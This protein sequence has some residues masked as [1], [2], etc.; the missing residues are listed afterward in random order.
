[1]ARSDDESTQAT[2]QLGERADSL[3]QRAASLN[4]RSR[5]LLDKVRN[6]AQVTVLLRELSR[7][8]ARRRKKRGR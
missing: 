2:R 1:M 8:A 4:E 6:T 7:L 3:R 5:E